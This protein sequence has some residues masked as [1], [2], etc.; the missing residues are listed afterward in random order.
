[1]NVKPRIVLLSGLPG[2]GKSTWIAGKDG[3]LSSD[4]LR[5][6]LADDP[7]NQNIHPRVF[8]VLRD[9]LKHRLELKRPVTYVDATNLTPYE[10]RPYIAIADL[11]DAEIE[12]LFFDVSITECIRRNQARERQ[13]P[14]DVIR[15]M[16]A[17]LVPPDV[18]EGFSL[19]SRVK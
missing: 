9:L 6:L 3:V 1:L 17:R 7:C 16:A 14:E 15:Q 5:Q 2:S 11:F 19:V 4:A 12:A 18:A 13:V 10:R 8:R